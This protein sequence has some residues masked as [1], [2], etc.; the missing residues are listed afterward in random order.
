MKLIVHP[1][2]KHLEPVLKQIS[3]LFDQGE[4]LYKSRNELR[5]LDVSGIAINIK[6]YR[7]PILLNRIAYSYFRS[8]KAKRAY[9]YALKLK[10]KGFDT[11]DPIAYLENKSMGLLRETYFV[12]T[13]LTDCRMM[14]EFADGS[15]IK[16]REDIVRAL[17]VYVARLHEA[18]VLHLDLSVGNILFRKEAAEVRFWLVD[19]NR[20]RFCTI[21]Q[22]LGCKNFE[23]LRGNADFFRLL[24]ISYANER[25]FDVDSCLDAILRHQEKSVRKFRAKSERKK[26]LRKWRLRR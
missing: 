2:F 20:M 16:G 18:G 10:E 15:D 22:A 6:R 13:H 26:T 4:T 9:E 11:P 1:E 25:G 8:S 24:A 17:G 19:L 5:F 21:D 7:T 3:D 14:R 23:R 12:S